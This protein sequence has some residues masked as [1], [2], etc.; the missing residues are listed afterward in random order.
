[1]HNPGTIPDPYLAREKCDITAI[2]EASYS[3]Y[4]SEWTQ[5]QLDAHHYDRASS[6]IIVH[7]T[8]IEEIG[9]LVNELRLRAEYLFVTDLQDQYYES[10]GAGWKTFIDAVATDPALA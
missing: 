7:S 1:M 9:N 4:Q 10:F 6:S 3:S 8:P 2:F 5:A